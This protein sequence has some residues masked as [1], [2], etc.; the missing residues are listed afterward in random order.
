SKSWQEK[1]ILS[2][3]SICDDKNCVSLNLVARSIYRQLGCKVVGYAYFIGDSIK[4][5]RGKFDAFGRAR[6]YGNPPV[7]NF[8]PTTKMQIASASK[9]L[10]ALAAIR[11]LKFKMSAPISTYFPSDWTLQNT[12]ANSI[13]FRE[14]LSQTSGVEWYY[15]GQQ[16][17]Q[18]DTNMKTF[19][20]AS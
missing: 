3:T 6:N 10:T 4:A 9:V 8:S 15:A 17:G 2:D 19:F 18:N 5:P 16:G 20:T 7:A 12:V 13:T 11:V 14:L 1:R